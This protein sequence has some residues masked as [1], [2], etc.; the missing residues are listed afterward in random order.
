MKT[1][2]R[3]LAAI[4]IVV[5][6][7]GCAPWIRTNGPFTSQAQNVTVNLPDGWMRLN[8]DDYIFITRDGERLQSVLIEVFHVDEKLKHTKKKLSKGMLPLESSEVIMDNISSNSE[9]KSFEVKENRSAK[10]AGHQCF[11]AIFTYRDGEGLKIKSVYYGFLDGEWFY[12]IRYTAPQRHY[13][14]KDFK[15][16]E[17]IVGSLKLAKA[18]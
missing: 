7:T 13:F 14:D 9:I 17:K 11:R 4:F 8:T 5:M 3:L 18:S 12:G 10:V 15:T 1:M 6:L 2:K 16:F